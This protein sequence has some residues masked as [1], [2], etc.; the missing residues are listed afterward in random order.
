MR[1]P[2]ENGRFTYGLRLRLEAGPV[3]R[4]DDPLLRMY[5]ASIESIADFDSDVAQD[6]RF[7]PGRAV[8]IETEFDEDG[9]S[10][11][12]LW[13][14]SG[15]AR[16]GTFA[17]ARG[18]PMVA[19]LDHG[20]DL[21][22]L[23]LSEEVTASNGR[24]ACLEVLVYS[25]GFVRVDVPDDLVLPRP[26]REPQTRIV[27][28]ADGESPVGFWDPSGSAGPASPA[29]LPLSPPLAE[30]LVTL[31]AGYEQLAQRTGEADDGFAQMEGLWARGALDHKAS[32]LWRRARLELGRRYAVGFQGPGMPTPVW[33]PDELC[34]D[35]DSDSDFE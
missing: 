19:A 12:G 25:P 21:R 13:D 14:A 20:L 34:A 31:R 35:E 6:D 18:C 27:L 16:A 30:A 26:V 28:L 1:T 7:S 11:V 5:G 17:F 4:N 24:R 23:V 32:V 8:R 22:G 9:D 29:D 15:V 33:S 3:L 10:V 2:D